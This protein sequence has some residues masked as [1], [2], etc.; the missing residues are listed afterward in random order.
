[1]GNT[2]EF[3]RENL[4]YNFEYGTETLHLKI[5]SKKLSGTF[6]IEDQNI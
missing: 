1:M 2:L 5:S 3:W 6:L 4:L